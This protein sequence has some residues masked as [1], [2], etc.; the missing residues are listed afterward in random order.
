MLL[1]RISGSPPKIQVGRTIANGTPGLGQRMLDQRLA[2]VV[3]QRRVDRGVGDAE[4]H[5]PP[6]PGA[7]RGV[8]QRA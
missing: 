3:A 6:D 5:D 1:A 8:E 7:A 2:A 4:V